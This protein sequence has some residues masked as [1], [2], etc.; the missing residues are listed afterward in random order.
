[1]KRRAESRMAWAVPLAAL[2][3][4]SAPARAQQPQQ[5]P[6]QLRI[7]AGS[8]GAPE[9]PAGP[10]TFL[11]DAPPVTG[12]RGDRGI[13]SRGLGGASGANGLVGAPATTGTIDRNPAHRRARQA[14]AAAA[15]ASAVPVPEECADG[16]ALLA[17]SPTGEVIDCPRPGEGARPI[18]PQPEQR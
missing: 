13:N 7:D 4:A 1:M 5:P 3:L 15:A 14:A 11:P 6:P 17:R 2:C 16:S 10:R 12:P 8:G 18:Q 9:V